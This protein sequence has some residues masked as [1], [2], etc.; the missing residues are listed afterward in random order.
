MTCDDAFAGLCESFWRLSNAI[1]MKVRDE[2]DGLPDFIREQAAADVRAECYPKEK[3]IWEDAY[4]RVMSA[5]ARAD[6]AA[7]F[8]PFT[9]WSEREN[10]S[11]GSLF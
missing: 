3:K 1:D 11:Q 8:E 10:L 9:P 2:T 7:G 5:M 6:I 4:V